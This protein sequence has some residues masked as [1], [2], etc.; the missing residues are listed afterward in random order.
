MQHLNLI[1]NSERKFIKQL[2]EILD[3][4]WQQKS[5]SMKLKDDDNE[6]SDA[7]SIYEGYSPVDQMYQEYCDYLFFTQDQGLEWPTDG[8]SIVNSTIKQMRKLMDLKNNLLDRNKEMKLI[9]DTERSLLSSIHS[10]YQNL[11]SLIL[12]E[13]NISRMKPEELANSQEILQEARGVFNDLRNKD[14]F[15]Y[16]KLKDSEDKV[17]NLQNKLKTTKGILDDTTKNY[18]KV[19]KAIFPNETLSSRPDSFLVDRKPVEEVAE[20]VIFDLRSRA[21]Q[22]G[23]TFEQ[24]RGKSE[25]E[26]NSY[27]YAAVGATVAFAVSLFFNLKSW[28]T[29]KNSKK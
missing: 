1:S 4:A 12:P 20:E 15:A 16:T 18:I 14:L 17:K 25:N 21:A 5:K 2:A 23:D 22:N 13:K 19:L 24:N 7:Q 29:N 9:S 26:K 27:A 8:I 28:F 3:T 6:S 11:A 10:K